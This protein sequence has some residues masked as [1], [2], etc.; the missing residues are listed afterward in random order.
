[1]MAADVRAPSHV[2]SARQNVVIFQHDKLVH[3]HCHLKRINS[4]MRICH[5]LSVQHNVVI[6]QNVQLAHAHCALP[7]LKDKLAYEH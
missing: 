6:F 4:R 5:I 3:A 7:F 1:M 2:S